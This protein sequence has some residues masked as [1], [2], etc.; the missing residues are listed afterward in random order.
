MAFGFGVAFG[1]L[2]SGFLVRFGFVVPFAFGA[3]LAA[4]GA[5]LVWTQVEE[6]VTA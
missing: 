1:P 5:V 6:T 2:S 4:V 3:V